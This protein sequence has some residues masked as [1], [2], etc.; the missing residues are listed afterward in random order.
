MAQEPLSTNHEHHPPAAIPAQSL[1]RLTRAI[2]L[3]N[4]RQTL[5]FGFWHGLV[6]GIGS[7]V[8]V[9]II[10]SVVAWVL[11]RLDFIP[12]I[13]QIQRLLQATGR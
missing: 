10:L 13:D 2:D 5:W 6:V 8:G 11:A 4:R 7:T 1:E 9:T 12:G 3:L